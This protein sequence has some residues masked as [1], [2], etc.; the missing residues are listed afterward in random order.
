[1]L[2][3]KQFS[4][5]G[6]TLTLIAFS[7]FVYNVNKTKQTIN[8]SYIYLFIMIIGKLFLILFGI[9]NDIVMLYIFEIII[10]I[11]LVYILMIKLSY[12]EN[13]AVEND[14]KEKKIIIK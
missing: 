5:I 8:L 10:L 1:M 6:S 13:E 11:E 3:F 4:I 7:M 9:L 14:L 12:A 2:K